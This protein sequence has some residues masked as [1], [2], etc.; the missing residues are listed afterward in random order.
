MYN[1]KEEKVFI[2][3]EH[4]CSIQNITQKSKGKV[5]YYCFIF[6][7]NFPLLEERKHEV[8]V[9]WRTGRSDMRKVR[10]M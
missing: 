4:I 5:R 6:D 7:L 8:Q 2:F 10:R 3:V 1:K 9:R